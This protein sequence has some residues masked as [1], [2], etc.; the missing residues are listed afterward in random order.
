MLFQWDVGR[1]SPETVE[2]L[3]W[4]NTRPREEEPLHEAANALFRGTVEA[5]QEI[6]RR[7]RRT[8]EH[9]RP[10]R[11]AVVDRNILRLGAYELL[12]RRET[13]P[14]VVINEALEIA[15]KFSGEDSVPFINGLL[16]HIRKEVESSTAA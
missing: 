14:P 5:V 6:D 15:R 13:P 1:D 12:Y 2:E 16:D 4:S 7:I 10:E 9:W 8:A 11:M 3:F